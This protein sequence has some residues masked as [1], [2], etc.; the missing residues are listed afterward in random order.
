M[1]RSRKP[2]QPLQRSW[3]PPKWL[4]PL[5][6]AAAGFLV[7]S[8]TF[9]VP[10]IFDDRPR[11]PENVSVH[12][13]WPISVPM[14]DSN[15]PFGMLTFAV[16]FAI[17]DYRVW[18]YHATNLAIHILAGLTLFGIIRRTLSRGDLAERY[19]TS[20]TSIAF[21]IALLWLVHPLNTQAVTYIIQRLESLMGLC[22]LLTLY[23]FIRAQDSPKRT[24]EWY[25]ASVCICA[26]GM[27]V[28][29]VM[30]T[31]PVMILW[32]HRAFVAKS[33]RALFSGPARYYYPA[34]CAT[35]GILAWAMLRSQVE[36]E[37]GNIGA[38]KGIS[39]LDYLLSQT[40]VITYY[41]RLSVWPYGQCLDYSWPVTKSAQHV[42]LP[43]LFVGTLF[44]AT[45]WAIFRHPTWGFLGG[46]FF[47]ILSPT[48]SVVPIMDLAFEQRMYLPL[49]AVLALLAFA[50]NVL[51]SKLTNHPLALQ[52]RLR[53]ISVGIVSLIALQMSVIT[54]GRNEVYRDEFGIWEDTVKKAPHN[55]RAHSTLAAK[56]LD[57]GK[58]DEAKI[59][60]HEAMRLN[61][62]HIDAHVNLIVILLQQGALE[63][64][65]KE[66][67][68]VLNL[69]DANP[70]ARRKAHTNLG[71]VLW[72]QGSYEEALTHF[73]AA[74]DL[75]PSNV[76]V[77]R[78]LARALSQQGKTQEALSYYNNILQIKPNDPQTLFDIAVTLEHAGQW[79]DAIQRYQQ[80][81]ELAN[82]F[83][84]A[85]HNL[86]V[87]LSARGRLDEAII[88]FHRAISLDPKSAVSY[89]GLG[90]ALAEQG[91]SEKAKECYQKA[92]AIEPS[93]SQATDRLNAL[94]NQTRPTIV[95][96]N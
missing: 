9:D 1:S 65:A 15:R 95:A 40:G 43:L 8:N 10:F 73:R 72:K 7:Y 74:S 6:L 2:A 87:V 12:R 53:W 78:N 5:L 56:L 32:Y 45:V 38:V 13:L 84:H 61:P 33:W 4:P 29:E 93:L 66:C 54:W 36:Y 57:A 49:I 35:W 82:D 48:S 25:I 34:L 52:Q 51:V 41:L 46:W 59:H 75:S 64:V 17:H 20:A 55:P 47:V 19:R 67:R 62:D 77:C 30:V 81:V 70:V 86:G 24:L 94:R 11:I 92:L 58:F 63:E 3:Q 44:V 96:P 23:C 28:K 80:A 83:V 91:Q 42:I 60:C 14:T 71:S 21:A 69:S 31:A 18:G 90:N 16:N 26:L 37:S 68:F 76:D 22:Y 27:G 88:H 50:T 39:P 79:D 89:L 85:H